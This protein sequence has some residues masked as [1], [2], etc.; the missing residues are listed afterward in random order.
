MKSFLDRDL[1]KNNILDVVKEFRERLEIL[2]RLVW[3]G[4]DDAGEGGGGTDL[5]EGPDVDL[6]YSSPG[7]VTIGR[8][9][10]TILLFDSGGNPLAEQPATE[11]GL[12]AICALMTAS[13]RI[14]IP[15]RTIALS[16][17]LTLPDNVTVSG[18]D[19]E[20]SVLSGDYVIVPGTTT[21][22]DI[23]IVNTANDAN[24][25]YGVVNA[26]DVEPGI[27]DHCKIE[28]TQSGAGNAYAVGGINSLAAG[29]GILEI[30]NSE[31]NGISVGGD[32][33]AGRSTAGRL[34]VSNTKARGSTDWWV[35]A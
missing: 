27:I 30:R 7:T 26:S 3:G 29:E 22:R 31:L 10:D 25:L 32:G 16:A 4:L 20:Y 5:E 9:G 8:G 21:L 34:H 17:P 14:E 23:R 1:I 2:E 24:P 35:F 28:V 15:Q 12:I 11:A 33:Y 13:D 18:M 19:W 6:I